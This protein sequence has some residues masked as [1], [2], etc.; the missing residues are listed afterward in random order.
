[1]RQFA[2]CAKRVCWLRKRS[3]RARGSQNAQIELPAPSAMA[4]WSS[5]PRAL[6]LGC[7]QVRAGLDE[8]L[9]RSDAM[10]VEP[11]GIIGAGTMGQ[12]IA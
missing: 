11:I 2:P 6:A 3:S 10:S 12:G 5:T 7:T 4:V 1:M 8:Q 9:S